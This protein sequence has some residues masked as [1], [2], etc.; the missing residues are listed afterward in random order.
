MDTT[1]TL[2]TIE[3]RCLRLE[4]ELE[5]ARFASRAKT[6]FMFNLSH[7]IRTP[8]NEVLGFAEIAK[9][10]IGEDEKIASCLERIVNS[11]E[12]LLAILNDI[13]DMSGAESGRVTTTAEEADL[14]SCAEEFR[15]VAEAMALQKEIRVDFTLDVHDRYVFADMIHIKRVVTALL[16]N[17]VQF[18]RRGQ[19]VD[20]S[21]LQRE[22]D[23]NGCGVYRFVVRDRGIGIS[24][25]FRDRLFEPFS[26]EK[27]G[28][29]QGLR[30]VGLGLS[31]AKSLV[32]AMNGTIE[33]ESKPGVGSVFTVT[34][35]LRIREYIGLHRDPEPERDGSRRLLLV[36]D[37]EPNRELTRE[38]LEDRGFSV[39]EAG[40]GLAAVERIT[41]VGPDYYSVILMDISMPVMDGYE[42][43][44]RI[45]AMFPERHIP[46]IAVSANAFEE[47]RDRSRRAGM[48]AHIAKPIRIEALYEA[49][50]KA[51][52]YT[53]KSDPLTGVKNR[54]AYSEA[55][56][57]LDR[58]IAGGTPD[59]FAMVVCD[60]ND[61]KK[62]NDARGHEAGDALIRAAAAEIC[63]AYIHS[64]VY[65]VGGDE[66]AVV[67]KGSD[68][69]DRAA[70]TGRLI[71]ASEAALTNGGPVVACGLADF[72]PGDTAAAQVFD[73]ADREMYR[74]KAELKR[75]T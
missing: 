42:A 75:R 69:E 63:A 13:L 43:A 38:L 19:T 57:I 11:A 62:I 9:K 49:I 20:L 70:L 58:S 16:S 6:D 73:R 50:I 33:V 54:L 10:H 51:M 45:R 25:G 1:P 29:R 7:D 36:E 71:A 66:F 12:H 15:S 3:Q 30:G 24:E 31:T 44:A 39:E 4:Q 32:E 56:S 28:E 72:A 37:N 8:M 22:I 61:L 5:R 64:P 60:I 35:P 52:S 47:D 26:R 53:M 67:L 40:N 23:A 46:I 68:Y 21:I 48:D 34:V 27:E 55:E 18:S 2:E 14:F 65:R 17:A 74:H 41:Q 59:P